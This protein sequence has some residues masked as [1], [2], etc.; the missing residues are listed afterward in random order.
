[1]LAR[2]LH[3]WSNSVYV[4]TKSESTVWL[5]T[6]CT[7]TTNLSEVLRRTQNRVIRTNLFWLIIALNWYI[8]IF[9]LFINLSR[10]K[11]INMKIYLS[12][13]KT[14]K[15]HIIFKRKLKNKDKKKYAWYFTISNLSET[16]WTI[17]NN[18]VGNKTC[19]YLSFMAQWENIK[20]FAPRRNT[21]PRFPDY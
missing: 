5:T 1:M 12:I 10:E 4:H 8:E 11:K 9:N 20:K 16:W 14:I 6:L 21:K 18:L 7:V 19:G 17:N 2:I 3:S 15:L 13:P